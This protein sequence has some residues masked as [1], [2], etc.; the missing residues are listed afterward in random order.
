ME[1]YH[2]PANTD[3]DDSEIIDYTDQSVPREEPV[4]EVMP[5]NS[6]EY[7]IGLVMKTAKEFDD[8]IF[9]IS[10]RIHKPIPGAEWLS[11]DAKDLRDRLV[12]AKKPIA[13]MLQDM[14]NA[15]SS[16]EGSEITLFFR[17][18]ALMGGVE[19]IRAEAD[20]FLG[21]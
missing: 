20:K 12:E 15:E 6:E 8:R 11:T 14:A 7:V 21:M 16:I 3:I 2:K 10:E 13:A 18:E 17:L 1:N 5:A 4:M 19:E 9:K